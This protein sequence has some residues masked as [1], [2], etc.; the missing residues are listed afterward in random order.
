MDQDIVIETAGLN[1]P[2]KLPVVPARQGESLNQRG[3]L[4]AD[5]KRSDKQV[6]LVDK[7]G[8]E[9][10]TMHG[11]SPLDQDGSDARLSEVDKHSMEINPAVV[12]KR[13]AMD[14]GPGPGKSFFRRPRRVRA[15][16]DP[17]RRTAVLGDHPG[18]GLQAQMGVD[19]DAQGS[20]CASSSGRR[21]VREGSSIRA[22]PTPMQ[23]AS[24][25]LRS[26]WVQSLDCSPVIRPPRPGR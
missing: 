17:R 7:P 15:A 2:E 8:P 18:F 24:S 20:R 13:Q 5:K 1:M 14:G 10:G 21:V 3:A 19:D 11:G 12:V 6:Y 23:T 26:R 4:A 16:E 9:K 25:V 22:V